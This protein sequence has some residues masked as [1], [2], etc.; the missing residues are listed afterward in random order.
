M[1]CPGGKPSSKVFAVKS[2]SGTASDDAPHKFVLKLS[3]V[4]HSTRM[5]EARSAR[6]HTTAE[7]SDTS[8]DWMPPEISGRSAARLRWGFASVPRPARASVDAERAKNCRRVDA[9]AARS[10]AIRKTFVESRRKLPALLDC[11]PTL[12]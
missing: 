9:R 12:F 8:P 1:S 4:E 6:A 10:V 5:R 7:P 11:R 2:V 3:T